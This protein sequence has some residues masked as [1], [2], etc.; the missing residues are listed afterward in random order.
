MASELMQHTEAHL[1]LGKEKAIKKI[2]Q[3]KLA[4]SW[5]H[6]NK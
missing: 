6:S 2:S 5:R 3:V 1:R 4:M